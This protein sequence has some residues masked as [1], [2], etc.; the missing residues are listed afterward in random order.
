MSKILPLVKG[1]VDQASDMKYYAGNVAY[2][3]DPIVS[4][5]KLGTELHDFAHAIGKKKFDFIRNKA[6]AVKS[7]VREISNG[8]DDKIADSYYA[9]ADSKF[10]NNVKNNDL[11]SL[12]SGD[13]FFDNISSQFSFMKGPELKGAQFV[14]VNNKLDEVLDK[15]EL[16]NQKILE[17]KNELKDKLA[18]LLSFDA[19]LDFDH[20]HDDPL[21]PGYHT[22]DRH[23]RHLRA[24]DVKDKKK[25][26]F[27]DY[28][29]PEYIYRN[30]FIG[31]RDID[32]IAENLAR[33]MIQK[34]IEIAISKDVNISAEKDIH[35]LEVDPSVP[36]DSIR[37]QSVE[38]DSIRGQSVSMPSYEQAH[39]PAIHYF[40]PSELL[41]YWRSS[42]LT[43]TP[44]PM[45]QFPVA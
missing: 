7:K 22:H 42:P 35:G 21:A 30:S 37:G 43:R 15:K 3:L 39:K 28:V 31:E 8:I 12:T 36:S 24:E 25:M 34:E 13:K 41:E 45:H 2:D 18:N 26:E 27:S 38:D 5:S 44:V 9:V 1:V 6:D 33:R 10:L 11:F 32:Y 29:W 20:N 40:P 16:T 14:P 4:V 19:F 23:H 17:K